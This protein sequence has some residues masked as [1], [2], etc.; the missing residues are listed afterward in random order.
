MVHLLG[1]C[2]VLDVCIESV[3]LNANEGLRPLFNRTIYP[4]D[5]TTNDEKQ[6]EFGIIWSRDGNLNTQPGFS[7]EP[8]HFALLV[9]NYDEGNSYEF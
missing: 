7:Y 3:Y 1:L 5:R 9:P 2:S 4:L 8:N 6:P